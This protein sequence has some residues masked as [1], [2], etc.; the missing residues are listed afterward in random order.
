MKIHLE[1]KYNINFYLFIIPKMP[2]L[3]VVEL[4]A[5]VGGFRIGLE[6][7]GHT[8]V[9]ANQ[10]EPKIKAQH[11]MNVTLHISKTISKILIQILMKLI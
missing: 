10:W 11:D 8:T 2:K 3:K 6:K 7:S 1:R 4:F 5:G 9:W